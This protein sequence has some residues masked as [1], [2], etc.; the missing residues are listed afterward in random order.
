M[1]KKTVEVTVDKDSVYILLQPGRKLDTAKCT[2]Y[3]HYKENT[4]FDYDKEGQLI[5]IELSGFKL[6]LGK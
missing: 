1:K 5:G 4:T 2:S 6:N 3:G